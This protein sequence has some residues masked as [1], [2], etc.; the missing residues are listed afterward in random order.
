MK[1]FYSKIN[2]AKKLMIF[3]YVIVNFLLFEI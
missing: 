3:D 2:K 1:F